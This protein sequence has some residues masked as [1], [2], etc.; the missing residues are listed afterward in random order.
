M[1]KPSAL[2]KSDGFS[3]SFM[4]FRF[5]RQAVLSCHTSPDQINADRAGCDEAEDEKLCMAAVSCDRDASLFSVKFGVPDD[6]HVFGDGSEQSLRIRT[7]SPDMPGAHLHRP[8]R[9]GH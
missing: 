5:T 7:E 9:S 1:E 8:H 6:I 2:S 3:V 4:P